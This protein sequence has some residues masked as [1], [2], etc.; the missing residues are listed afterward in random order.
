MRP[1]GNQSTDE[2]S[3]SS[4]TRGGSK[5]SPKTVQSKDRS[6]KKPLCLSI[7]YKVEEEVQEC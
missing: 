5:A 7:E 4:N 2:I 1:A 3:T 6:G